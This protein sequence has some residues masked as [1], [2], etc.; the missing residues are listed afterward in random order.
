MQLLQAAYDV[1]L[2]KQDDQVPARLPQE[3]YAGE[4]LLMQVQ[5]RQSGHYS[6]VVL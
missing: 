6:F 5:L 3:L 1:A 2:Q 4:A